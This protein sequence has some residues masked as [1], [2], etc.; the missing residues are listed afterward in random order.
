MK[1]YY[2]SLCEKDRRRYAAIEAI[3]LGYGGINYI[4]QLFGCN[5][6]TVHFGMQELESQSALN[7]QRIRNLG[8]GRKS[9]L[10]TL[11]GL[12]EAF[13]RV[14]EEKTAGSPMDE[15][16]KWTHLTRQQIAAALALQGF[17]VSVTVVD[18]LP[19][20]AMRT[21]ATQRPVYPNPDTVESC[22]D[23]IATKRFLA[24]LGVGVAPHM[25]IETEDDILDAADTKFSANR[26]SRDQWSTCPLTSQQITFQD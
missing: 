11:D 22:I 18:Q 15:A 10:A 17:T 13:S 26:E 19:L 24:D 20:A 7:Q 12:E 21:V 23:R 6:R 14:L 2:A 4:C 16:M 8:A 3:K 25:L 1:C 9:A 5:Y